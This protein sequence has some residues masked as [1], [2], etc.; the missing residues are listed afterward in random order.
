M[1]KFRYI[2]IGFISTGDEFAPGNNGLKDQL[3]LLKWVKKHIAAFGGDPDNVTVLGCSAG[4]WS[5]IIHMISPISQGKN[6]FIL[7]YLQSSNTANL[8]VNSTFQSAIRMIYLVF[9]FLF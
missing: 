8:I 5:I 9:G 3:L 1:F 4:A 2:F 7:F 6:I